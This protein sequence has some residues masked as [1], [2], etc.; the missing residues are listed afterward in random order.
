MLLM[1]QKDIYVIFEIY[2]NIY[3][4]TPKKKLKFHVNNKKNLRKSVLVTEKFCQ[5]K[6][7]K[8]VSINENTLVK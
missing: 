1:H 8:C 2:K 4:N 3:V 7:I 6:L 5:I